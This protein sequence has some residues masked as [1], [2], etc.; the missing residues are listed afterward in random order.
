MEALP[1]ACGLD[2]PRGD[3]G[4]E[5]MSGIFGLESQKDDAAIAEIL[6]SVYHWQW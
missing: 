4:T 3:R 2:T 6:W 5:F 1:D